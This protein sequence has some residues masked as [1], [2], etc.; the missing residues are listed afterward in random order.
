MKMQTSVRVDDRFYDESK[1]VFDAFGMS[2]GDAVNLFLAKVA[3]EKRIP[4]DISLPSAELTERIDRLETNTE[5]KT[6]NNP[7][8]LFKELG[9]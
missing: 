9:I 2:F 5:T 8:D 6:Y 3:L 7:N 4:F 1:K